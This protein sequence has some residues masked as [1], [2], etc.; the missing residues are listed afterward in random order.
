[1]NKSDESQELGAGGRGT[2][3]QEPVKA[4]PE[5]P[6][7]ATRIGLQF[8]E[9][10]LTFDEWQQA[11]MKIARMSDSTAW[12]LGDW[13]VYGE[14]HYA[15]RY[16]RVVEATVVSYQTLRNYAWVARRF[17]LSR[18]RDVLTFYHHMEVARL[19]TPEQERWL[20]RAVERRWSVRQLRQH[21][22]QEHTIGMSGSQAHAVLPKIRAD[23]ERL[24]RWRAAAEQANE[25]FEQW[26]V[27]TLDQAAVGAPDD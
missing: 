4:T 27:T 24:D 5:Y 25:S 2:R 22:K 3:N 19:P 20:D 23:R 15:D 8:P 12:F 1:M 11:G 9:R 16:R 17:P 14:S 6:I 7:R 10:D 18:R 13:I 26:V 21:V